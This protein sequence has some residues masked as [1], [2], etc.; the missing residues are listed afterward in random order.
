MCREA[1][2]SDS[3]KLWPMASKASIPANHNASAQRRSARHKSTTG[4]SPFPQFAGHF[5][6][7]QR[8]G[9]FCAIE[10][11]PTPPRI[12]SIATA[13]TMIPIPPNHAASGDKRGWREE[14]NPAPPAYGPRGGQARERF[15]KRIG[16]REV[17][18]SEKIKG[19]APT[20]PSTVQNAPLSETPH[21]ISV[22]PS[23]C[24]SAPK[25]RANGEGDK[26]GLGKSAAPPSR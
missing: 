4:F 6:I 9:H 7:F 18:L 21:G 8:A 14:A 20:L 25:H 15:K 19:S 24:G 11:H 23:L 10:L 5:V 2:N 1:A 3:R 16:N 26:K 17:G 13:N 12:G 22:H